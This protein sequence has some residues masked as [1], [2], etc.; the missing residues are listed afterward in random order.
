M[1][2]DVHRAHRHGVRGDSP[3]APRMGVRVLESMQQ[4]EGDQRVA[5]R[6]GNGN[7]AQVSAVR[8]APHPPWPRRECERAQADWHG[9]SG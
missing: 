9:R 3:A 5:A 7:H 4:Q 2:Q 1:P 6:A 8:A